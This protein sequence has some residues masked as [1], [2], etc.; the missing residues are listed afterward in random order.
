MYSLKIPTHQITSMLTNKLLWLGLL[1]IYDNDNYFKPHTMANRYVRNSN[2]WAT[3]HSQLKFFFFICECSN[4]CNECHLNEQHYSH[5]NIFV[6]W[7][8]KLQRYEE[9]WQKGEK[10]KQKLFSPTQFIEFVEWMER[11]TTMWTSNEQWI[12]KFTNYAN[13]IR[14]SEK[15]K[16]RTSFL[17]SNS[18]FAF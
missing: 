6:K 5:W 14:R 12:C 9:I 18:P 4:V 8:K 15:L 10:N 7:K 13:F 3:S 2:E 16:K 17:R 1:S 11:V